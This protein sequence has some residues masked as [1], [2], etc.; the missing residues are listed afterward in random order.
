[1]LR[2][3]VKICEENSILFKNQTKI[4]ENLH[5]DLPTFMT[6]LITNII[7]VAFVAKG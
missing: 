5:V 6:A 1:M 3:G 2:V 4:T 7:V